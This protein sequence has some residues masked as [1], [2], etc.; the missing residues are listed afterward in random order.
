MKCRNPSPLKRGHLVRFHEGPLA[1]EVYEADALP[2]Y[3]YYREP[4]DPDEDVVGFGSDLP[5][6]VFPRPIHRYDRLP[7]APGSPT[8]YLWVG[9]QD[10]VEV[11]APF[12]EVLHLPEAP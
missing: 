8:A 4:E 11:S 9:R 10:Q 12:D 1:D 7:D 6:R 3:V 2:E 5:R